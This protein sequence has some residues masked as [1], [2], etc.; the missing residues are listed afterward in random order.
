MI[1]GVWILLRGVVAPTLSRF[2]R[3]EGGLLAI[4]ASLILVHGAPPWRMA[5]ELLVSAVVLALAYAYND[6]HDCAVDVD[7]PKKDRRLMLFLCAHRAPILRALWLI[8]AAAVAAAYAL[9]GGASAAAVAAA[10]LINA[11]Y[12]HFLKRVAVIDVL[13]IGLGGGVYVLT[14]GIPVD[15]RVALLVFVMTGASHVFQTLGDQIVDRQNRIRTTAV[16]SPRLA[17]VLL[18]AFCAAGVWVVEPAF[19]FGVALTAFIPFAAHL[20]IA[21]AERAWLVSKAYFA[22]LWLALLFHGGV[23]LL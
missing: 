7:N 19:G 20:L 22:V 1:S 21:D 6:V 12:S 17:R 11:V 4:N 16:L 3:A 18:V 8:S 2:R 14:P 15:P 23:S 5:L 10:L 9:L 13:W